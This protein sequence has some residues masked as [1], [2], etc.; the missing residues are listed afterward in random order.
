MWLQ[1]TSLTFAPDMPF[2]EALCCLVKGDNV[3]VWNNDWI[4]SRKLKLALDAKRIFDLGVA[5][6]LDPIVPTREV[7]L[8]MARGGYYK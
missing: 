7:E 8:F 5:Q 4:S 2:K 6:K 3:P 1:R